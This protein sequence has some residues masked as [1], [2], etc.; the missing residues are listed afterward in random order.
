MCG[1]EGVAAFRP[2]RMDADFIEV[3]QTV[4]QPDVPIGGAAGADMAQHLAVLA[5][6]M[7]GAAAR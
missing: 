4:E 6:Q 1:S 2:A 7:L 5:G 3:E